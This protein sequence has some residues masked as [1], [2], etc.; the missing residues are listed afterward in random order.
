ML[1]LDSDYP[2]NASTTKPGVARGTCATT[3]GVPATVE[4]EYPNSSVTYSNIRFGDLNSTYTGGTTTTTT[5]GTGTG[6]TTSSGSS[7]TQTVYGQCGGTGY[8]GPTVC[9]SGSTCTY[10][11]AYYSQ[12]LP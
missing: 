5:T 2:T 3:S 11:N 9:A 12:C 8:T 6:T 4:S 7:A 1:W 10:S